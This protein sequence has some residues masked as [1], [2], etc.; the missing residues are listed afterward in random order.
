MKSILKNYIDLLTLDKLKTYAQ[1]Q[2]IQ[3]NEFE[4]EFILK[5]VKENFDDIL[6]NDSKY[7]DLLDKNINH[8]SYLKIKDLYL[9]YKNRY[10]GYLF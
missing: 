1:K 2:D 10:K 6:I 9:Y 7:L 5:L 8:D 4:L 3:L